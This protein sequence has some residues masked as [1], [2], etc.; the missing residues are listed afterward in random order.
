MASLLAATLCHEFPDL[1]HKFW[2]IISTEI[3]I[4]R[5]NLL[6]YVNRFTMKIDLALLTRGNQNLI[7]ED[8]CLIFKEA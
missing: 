2:N 8:N 1:Q 7:Y 6:I 3:Y 4:L 5:K